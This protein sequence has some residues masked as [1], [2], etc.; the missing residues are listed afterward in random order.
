MQ[1]FNKRIDCSILIEEDYRI[2][3][4]Q[5]ENLENVDSFRNMI[6]KNA[7]AEVHELYSLDKNASEIYSIYTKMQQ[8]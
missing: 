6:V 7:F 3:A 4:A 8:C 1:D 5:I 2:L